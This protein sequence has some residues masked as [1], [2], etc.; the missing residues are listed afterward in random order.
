MSERKPGFTYFYSETLQQEIAVSIKSGR[1]YCS[2]G[3]QYSPEELKEI[4]KTYGELPLQVHIVKKH[5]GG[6]IISAGEE[7]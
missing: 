2:D 7:K 4:Q 1:V 5:F 6:E 3:V